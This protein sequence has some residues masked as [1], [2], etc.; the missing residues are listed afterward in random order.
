MESTRNSGQYPRGAVLTRAILKSCPYDAHIAFH[1]RPQSAYGKA[2][3][4][5]VVNC[6]CGGL[7]CARVAL[8]VTLVVEWKMTGGRMGCSMLSEMAPLVTEMHPQ[9][10][11]CLAR[12]TTNQSLC[13]YKESPKA[14]S[15]P[16]SKSG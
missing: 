3:L 7:T 15:L 1:S 8:D 10:P 4:A 2:A 11:V 5:Q 12:S 6:L 13:P 9:P 14:L 16:S